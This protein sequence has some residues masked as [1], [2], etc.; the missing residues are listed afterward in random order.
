LRDDRERL[1]D[2]SE[3]IEKVERYVAQGR[4]AFDA[5]ELIQTWM[6]HH[7]QIIGEAVS[8]LTDTFRD[9]HTEVPWAKIIGMRN[10]LIHQYFGIDHDAVWDAVEQ[11]LPELKTKINA[12]LDE[13]Q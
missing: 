12:I 8:G 2:I 3:A 10:I 4:P 9:D 6:V 13:S 1:R 7:L 5:N 11:S